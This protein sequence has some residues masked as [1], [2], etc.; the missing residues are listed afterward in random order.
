MKKES[1]SSAKISHRIEQLRNKPDSFS[2]AIA[3][4][5][6]YLG[7][8]GLFGHT[9]YLCPRCGEKTLLAASEND[10]VRHLDRIHRFEKRM[11]EKYGFS[12]QLD[13]RYFCTRC[14]PS[15]RS[16]RWSRRCM[17][18]TPS[19]M[20][21]IIRLTRTGLLRRYQSDTQTDTCAA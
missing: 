20:A 8:R 9:R 2:V 21:A 3:C 14:C 4:C 13:E 19:A 16:S 12:I 10:F 1:P 18:A 11:R 7:P 15:V 17:P 5:Y 6:V